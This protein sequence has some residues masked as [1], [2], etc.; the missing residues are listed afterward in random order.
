M[1]RAGAGRAFGI[2]AAAAQSLEAL[3][4]AVLDQPG[5]EGRATRVR[6]AEQFDAVGAAIAVDVVDAQVFRGAAAGAGPA[7]VAEDLGAELGIPAAFRFPPLPEIR[8]GPTVY[9]CSFALRLRATG[10]PG[11]PVPGRAAVRILARQTPYRRCNA[12]VS[13]QP[14]NGQVGD[15]TAG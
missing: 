14:D 9:T 13:Q 7:V 5:P 3:R 8:L 11:V 2:V 6:A 12:L 4:E 15:L 10:R 1:Q